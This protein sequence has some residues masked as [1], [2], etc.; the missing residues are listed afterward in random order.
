MGWYSD[1]QPIDIKEALIEGVVRIC[2]AAGGFGV[3]RFEEKA[4]A[5]S[6][7]RAS[8]HDSSM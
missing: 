7:R 2:I 1:M 4:F 3:G 8:I 5:W 6:F